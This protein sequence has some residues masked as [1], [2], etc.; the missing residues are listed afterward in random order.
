MVD[1]EVEE[2]P[3][4]AA[5]A[6]ARRPL[7]V[8]IAPEVREARGVRDATEDGHVRHGR[9][10]QQE[11]DRGNHGEQHPLQDAEDEDADQG[12][13][14]DPE[15]EATHAPQPPDLPQVDQP[16]HR[17]EHDRGQHRLREVPEEAREEQQGDAEGDGRDDQ[18]HAGHGARL[19]VYR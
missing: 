4:D 1:V 6:D 13:D 15:L 17:H 12:Y 5:D 9:A 3:L 16:L 7:V 8:G 2:G 19:L 10:M 18:R 11:E 14:R